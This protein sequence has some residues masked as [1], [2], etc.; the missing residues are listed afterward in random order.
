MQKA[1]AVSQEAHAAWERVPMQERAEIFLRAGD[2]VSGKYRMDLL[3][4]TMLGQVGIL[5]HTAHTD[6]HIQ[7]HMHTH[8]DMAHTDTV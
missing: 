4:T 8:V 6:T 2:L 7:I 5:T 1:I 3:A